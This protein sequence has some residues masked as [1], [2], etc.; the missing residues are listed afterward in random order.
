MKSVLLMVAFLLAPVSAFAHG[1]V[2]GGFSSGILHP[3]LGLDHLLAMVSVGIVSTQMGGRA[4]WYAPAIFVLVMA[5][6]GLIGM[7]DLRFNYTE[8]MISWSV[9]ILGLT[10]AVNARFSHAAIY[11]FVAFFAI[12]HGYAHGREIPELAVSW[13]YIA[14]FMTG[15]A[16]LHILG[17]LIGHYSKKIKD[18]DALLRYSGAFIAGIGFHIYL[19]ITGY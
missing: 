19:F 6:G 1:I 11:G 18:G 16:A 7:E 10:I 2:Y 12:F 17:V 13:A 15:T 9:I 5:I 4:I 14:G 8:A 3:V